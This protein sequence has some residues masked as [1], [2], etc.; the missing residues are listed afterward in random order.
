MVSELKDQELKKIQEQ[1][2]QC[3]EC[4]Y[5]TFWCPIYQED[6]K[7]TSVAR[8]KIHMGKE[9]LSGEKQNTEEFEKALNLC[10]LCRTCAEHCPNKVDTPSV[11]VAARADK[12]K[13]KGIHFPYNLIY[14][15]LL[16]RRRLFGNCVKVASKIQGVIFPKTKGTVRHLPMFVSALGKGRNIPSIAP[17]FMRE[18]VPEVNKPHAVATSRMKVGY[19]I[20]CTTDFVF[21]QIGRKAVDFL[22]KHGI[23]VIVPRK[24]GC[25]G[26]PI[27]LGAGDFETGRKLADTNIKAFE[28]AQVDY[29]VCGCA[30]CTSA[31]K[32]YVKYLA[33][34]PERKKSYTKFGDKLHDISEF[35]IDVLK[36]SSEFIPAADV[37]GKKVT[38][39]DSC[40][41]N[42][43]LHITEQPRNIIKSLPGVEF[44]E[45]TRPDWCCGM[46]GTFSIYYYDT[47]KKIADKKIATIKD[48]GAD[49]LAVGCPGCMVQF[50][51]NCARHKLPIKVKHIVELLG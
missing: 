21:P 26:A 37:I 13:S 51:D 10:M 11:V 7:E 44:V 2:I 24:Q 45:M 25:C 29:I 49:I 28:E 18:T 20:G 33:D 1:L 46:A 47:S 23:E 35:V 31:M 14:R 48:T 22:T 34:T 9:L 39:H 50:I 41:L 15:Q 5:C 4:G 19:F 12:I 16:P 42:R 27:Y 36:L 40:H 8:G 30:T 17:K 6:P 43:Y 32:D 3:T 38:W